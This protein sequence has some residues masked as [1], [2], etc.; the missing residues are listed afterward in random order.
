MDKNFQ[1]KGQWFLPN[2]PE[3]RISGT[4][5]FDHQEGAHLEL[6]GSLR[7]NSID[8][9][10]ILGVTSDSQEVTLY[11]CFFSNGGGPTLKAGY[12][13]GEPLSTYTVN[14]IFKGHHFDS[15]EELKFE[16]LIA[17]IYNLEEWLEVSGFNIPRQSPQEYKRQEITMEYKLPDPIKFSIH[18][19]IQCS[20]NF[21]ANHP[22]WTVFRKE[23]N[24]K[25]RSQLIFER[26][27]SAEFK[28]H[29]ETLNTFLFFLTLGLYQPTYPRKLILQSKQFVEHISDDI[30]EVKSIELHFAVRK[31]DEYLHERSFNQMLFAYGHIKSDFETIIQSWFNK[32]EILEPVYNLLFDHFYLIG[33][34]TENSFLNLAQAAETFHARLYDHTKMLPVDYDKMK[35][36]ILAVVD[37]KYHAWLKEQFMFGN[38]LSL[39]QRLD[40]LVA[41]YSNPV[42]ESLIGDKNTFIQEVKHSRNHYTH[43]PKKKKS[44]VL[45][46]VDLFHLGQK[47]KGLLVA[48]LLLETGVSKEIIEK[49]M[50]NQIGYFRIFKYP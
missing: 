8:I 32:R 1:L 31:K 3:Q 27:N 45:S 12:E 47:I 6:F 13:I 46:S 39:H 37:P 36:D 9:P 5:V 49:M 16:K 14:I 24:I 18:P 42:V 15:W 19:E 20:F 17:E 28:I 23:L 7:T 34:Y 40:E 50:K 4:L 43:Y 29:I 30:T 26:A 41:K 35:T 10:I 11:K 38:H 21:V 22:G 25:Q 2:Q 33:P 44:K 48:A